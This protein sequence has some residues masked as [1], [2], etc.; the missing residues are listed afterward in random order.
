MLSV[1]LYSVFVFVSY[2]YHISFHHP[3]YIFLWSLLLIYFNCTILVSFIPYI[4][5]YYIST[6]YI[7]ENLNNHKKTSII[8]NQTKILKNITSKKIL[9]DWSLRWVFERDCSWKVW[10]RNFDVNNFHFMNHMYV[11]TYVTRYLR[12]I[13]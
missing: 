1:V 13:H 12:S 9:L 11:S 7:F 4:L 8:N 3:N 10:E 2:T 6:F 5:F